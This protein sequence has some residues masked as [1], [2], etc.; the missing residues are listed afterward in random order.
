MNIKNKIL[1]N[2]MILINLLRIFLISQLKKI[3]K[4]RKIKNLYF[5]PGI[6]LIRNNHRTFN[7]GKAKYLINSSFLIKWN[8]LII[9]EQI[10]FYIINEKLLY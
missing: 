2:Q 3:Y 1:E 4:L 9:L 7:S 6:H 10:Q 8:I 5:L